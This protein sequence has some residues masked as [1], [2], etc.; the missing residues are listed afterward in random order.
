MITLRRLVG[1][2]PAPIV[3]DV[4]TEASE[5]FRRSPDAIVVLFDG[6]GVLCGTQRAGDAAMVTLSP[7]LEPEHDVE[8]ARLA[9]RAHHTDR[10]LVV[11]ST[12]R[13]LGV[14]IDRDLPR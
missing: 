13:L 4:G 6:N 14:A 5:I 12:G 3:V 10:V 2:M 11:T 8:M 9:M 1:R 7:V